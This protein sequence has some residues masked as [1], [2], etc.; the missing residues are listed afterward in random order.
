MESVSLADAK[1]RLSELIDRVE[2]GETIEILRRG[3]PVARLSGVRRASK[4]F[5]LE[6]MRKLT[7]SMKKSD[8]SA[9]DLIRAMRD[10]GY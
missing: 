1:A 4:P 6:E 7:D 8:V 2:K 10:E 9:A 3:K 5:P